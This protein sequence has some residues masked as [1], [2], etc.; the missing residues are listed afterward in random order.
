MRKIKK[1]S[2]I[3][4]QAIAYLSLMALEDLNADRLGLFLD[5]NRYL[6]RNGNTRFVIDYQVPYKNLEFKPRNTGF[7]A[8]L[9]VSIQLAYPDSEAF[10]DLKSFTN[11][12]GVSRK[13]DITSDKSYLDRIS[14]SPPSAG[15]RLR[16]IFEDLNTSKNYHWEYEMAPLLPET[17]LSDI[18]IIQSIIPDST[19]YSQ[20]FSRNGAAY[21]PAVSGIIS[22][23]NQDSIYIYCEKYDHTGEFDTSI[24]NMV[25]D[26]TLILVTL[27][28]LDSNQTTESLLFPINISGL[29]SGK[30]LI[31]LLVKSHNEVLSRSLDLF[32]TEPQ[33]MIYALFTDV[34]E[35]FHLIR[36]LSSAKSS[37]D[38]NSLTNQAK[39]S[40]ISNFWINQAQGQNMTVQEILTAYRKRIDYCNARFSHFEKGWKSD[41][42]RIYIRNGPPDDSESDEST[43]YNLK[44]G[45]KDYQIWKYLG[46]TQAVYIFVDIAMNGNYKL[47]YAD[48]DDREN[49]NPS[50]KKYLGSDFD[51]SRLNY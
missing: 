28:A 45:R 2:L 15:Y 42:G 24:L 22:K 49:T 21:V 25:K 48:N 10:I 4:L 34:N 5:V 17:G 14:L 7:Y 16:L 19:Q 35:E 51:E 41:M 50:W 44:G 3:A 13:Y 9:Q 30:Y 6:D 36:Y 38:W 33:E 37:S 12:I 31:S 20:K 1:L 32:I 26:S 43:D 11:N 8:E 46:R 29:A 39:R 18:E 47:I 23:S 40:Y 27:K